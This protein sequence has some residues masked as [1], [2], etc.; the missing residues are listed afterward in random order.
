LDYLPRGPRYPR[1]H[2]LGLIGCGGI[3]QYHLAAAQAHRVEVVALADIRRDSAEAL[4]DK[5]C[6][7]AEVYTDPS[8]LLARDDITVVE[9]ATHP[10]VRVAQVADALRAGKH[11]LS[12]KPFTYDLG[13]AR[14]LIRLAERRGLS[15]GVNQNGR[16]APQFAALLAAVR[17]GVLGEIHSLDLV[18]AW[19]HT[20]LRGL[21]YEKDPHLILG[22]FGIHWFDVVAKVFAGR[23]PRQV[24][25]NAVPA[26]RQDMAPPM[27]A[28]AVVNYGDGLATLGFSAYQSFAPRE[29]LCCVGSQGT[30]RGAANVANIDRL[31]FT[32]A[33]GTTEIKLQGKWFPDG[34]RG[35]LGEF[36]RSLEEGR[37]SSI[38]ARDNLATLELTF[39]A[40][41][42]SVSGRPLKP[43]T[44]RV[45]PGRTR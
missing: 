25:A 36:L 6:P 10:A 16:W 14:R 42:S 12:Q 33:R 15:L 22:D 31:E 19:D 27:L 40:L 45:A 11:V 34:F 28:N 41:A 3:A 26:P 38:S 13:E 29:Y 35:T 21:P 5:F 18:M 44:V 43:G 37:E 23:T 8:A 7:E 17:S 2:K 1:R 4:R 24:F 39:A 30:L 32:N 9:V 20:W